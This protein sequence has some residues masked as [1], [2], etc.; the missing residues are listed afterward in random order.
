MTQAQTHARAP[1]ASA[2]REMME[3][4]N[5]EAAPLNIWLRTQ[6]NAPS[7]RPWFKDTEL[8]SAGALAAGRVAA[9]QIEGEAASVEVARDLAL[10]RKD[11]R[12]RGQR[13]RA[14]DRVRRP[15]AIPAHQSGSRRAAADRGG[16]A[17]R[18]VDL[19]SRRRR[20]RASAQ[21][22][23]E[24]HDPVAERRLHECRGRAL[25]RLA[26]RR[27]PDA[28]RHVA[29]PRQRRE[30]AGDVDRHAR[31]AGARIPRSH[32]ARRGHAGRQRQRAPAADVHAEGYS[33]ALY[34]RGGIKPRFVAHTRGISR[35]TTP[36]IHFRGAD[37]MGALNALRGRGGRSARRRDDRSRQSGRR[38][39]A[40]SHARLW[41]ADDPRRAK[42]R[43][44]SAR[45]RAR[46]S[47][48]WRAGGRPSLPTARSTGKRTTS[49]SCRTSCGG[50]I[51]TR[52]R[53]TRCSTR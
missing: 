31:L 18:G 37:I 5:V 30:R 3:A 35:N 10:S 1:L 6:A 28:E 13:R 43:C 50:G 23:R 15:A 25:P 46:C 26:R 14:A 34:S 22:Q 47:S 38:N 11:R 45:P 52:A 27:D 24:P 19:Q 8:S 53:R 21:P 41:R 2:A 17:L 29:R 20:A 33:Q 42:R 36:H 39:G 16:A 40:V 9:A 12:H 7:Q 44:T 51:S 4:L 32:L 48:S 49:S